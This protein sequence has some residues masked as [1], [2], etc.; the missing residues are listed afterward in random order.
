MKLNIKET[1]CEKLPADPILEN[2]RRQVKSAVFSYV[3]PKKTK[4]PK[5]IHIS[6]EMALELGISEEETQSDFFKNVFTGNKIYPNTKP[7][8]MCYGG[9]QFGNWAGQLGDGR[10]INLFE[11]E[12]KNKNWKVQLKGA[13]E[14]PYS[15]TADGLAVLRSSIREYLCSEAMFYLGVPTTR[16]LSLSLSGD[17]VLRDILY[18]GN[19]AYEKGAIVSRISPSFL[20]F[21][22]YEI[23]SA[24]NDVKN[25]KVLVDYTI[26]HHFSHLENSSKKT[27]LKFFN[28]VSERTLEMIIH[29]QRVGFVHG[30][31]NTDNMS[32]LGLTIDY[33]P[34]GWLEDFDYSW[35]PNTTD[36]QHKRYRFG[37]QP[38]IGLW[39]LYKLANALYPLIEEVEP[40][41]AILDQYK[42]DFQKK[43][44][45]MMKSKLGLFEEV[46]NDL[47]LIQNLEDNLQLVETDM[48]IFF[49]NL[50]NFKGDKIGFEI[51]KKA[52][53][54]VKNISE[55]VKIQWNIWFKNY[56]DRLQK[57]SLN[58]QQRKEKMDAVNPK[59]VL[60]NYMAQL[61]IDAANE[62]DYSLINQLFQ[63][64]KK[65]YDEQPKN[66]K[67][68]TKRPDWA[69]HKVGCSMLSCSS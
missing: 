37:N 27:Y 9:H 19:P 11:V 62:G 29:W 50:S 5:V 32:I 48:T 45:L 39:N 31:M 40:L 59:Y 21:G 3:N 43:S 24:R 18:D 56:A 17:N 38:N 4:D 30:V 15:R 58:H 66:E 47:E 35:T 68:F 52:F 67:W 8:A 64:L 33:G 23:F 34:Y 44:F 25:L 65:P 6:N 53:Y 60:R 61:A 2:S 22:N 46:K 7:F 54:D 49:R 57:E 36:R 42:I 20:R 13:G 41:E 26:K 10:A 1:F 28:E 14:T 16:A 55:Q 63:L 69:K 51:I 12:H